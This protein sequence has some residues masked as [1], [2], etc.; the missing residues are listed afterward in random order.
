MALFDI[1]LGEDDEIIRFR[2]ISGDAFGIA[3]SSNPQSEVGLF[4]SDP[5]AA[6]T[7]DFDEV[8]AFTQPSGVGEGYGIAANNQ[9]GVQYVA[10]GAC[11]GRHDRGLPFYQRVEQR[12]FTSIGFTNQDDAIALT[13]PPSTVS[14]SQRGSQIGSQGV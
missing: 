5:R 14:V 12:R 1:G 7:L 4:R 9:L 8:L 3:G 2:K 11:D 6:H 13:D 10:R